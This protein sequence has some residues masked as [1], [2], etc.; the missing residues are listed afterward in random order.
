M[1][2]NITPQERK[3]LLSFLKDTSYVQMPKKLHQSLARF[4]LDVNSLTVNTQ[5]LDHVL[6]IMRA[7]LNTFRTMA[8]RNLRYGKIERWMRILVLPAVVKLLF[9]VLPARSRYERQLNDVATVIT[10]I[11]GGS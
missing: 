1:N 11:K 5:R 4:A 10:R 9:R 2:V 6:P 3:I 8:G 7:A